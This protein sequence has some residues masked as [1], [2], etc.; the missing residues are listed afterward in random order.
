M[1]HACMSKSVRLST[2]L[3]AWTKARDRIVW[4]SDNDGSRGSGRLLLRLS[5]SG[6]RRFYYR[7]TVDRVRVTVSLGPYSKY[8]RDGA[9]TLEQARAKG[10]AYAA[11]HL[12]GYAD[13][14]NR[15]PEALAAL[16]F[17]TTGQSGNNSGGNSGS[18]LQLCT[19][20][21]Q[22]L[23][24]ANKPTA[25]DYESVMR[26]HIAPSAIASLNA[27]KMVDPEPVVD[28]LG[29]IVESG[30]KRTAKKVRSIL[31]AAYAAAQ[32]AKTDAT[33]PRS[34]RAFGITHNPIAQTVLRTSGGV[35]NRS[36]NKDELAEVWGHV[37]R[38]TPMTP[39][40]RAIRLNILLGG[41][42]CEQLL[43]VRK[44]EVDMTANTILLW[45]G[46]G[47]RESPRTHLLPLIPMAKSDVSELLQESNRVGSLFA[48]RIRGKTLSP[49][50]VTRVV[51]T[52]SGQLMAAGSIE[53][54][55]SY[56]DLRRTIETHMQSLHIDDEVRDHIQSHGLTGV[57]Q[58]HY[59]R[60]EYLDEKR[61][62]LEKW[63]AYLSRLLQSSK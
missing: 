9:L 52:I 30:E 4:L 26:T 60:Y 17:S 42:R 8:S 12:P 44:D 47:R 1:A 63:A 54:A 62:A 16:G 23:R 40:V 21:V 18:V 13:Q 29:A 37:Q 3:I 20:Y 38:T 49:F 7:H 2:S 45:D 19:A 36:L 32:R 11:T 48:G 28:L 14:A 58:R 25:S 6:S 57:R 56:G 41:Q 39:Q 61:Q 5:P 24:A 27:A 50:T 31:G 53:K 46:K 55:F 43:R 59:S 33:V 15:Q 51:T 35:G 34:L 22:W 10:R